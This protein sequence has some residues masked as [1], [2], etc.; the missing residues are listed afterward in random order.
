MLVP[1]RHG[2]SS[3]YRYGYQGSE[4]DD[5]LKGEG[6]SLN[7]TFRMHD[8]RVGRFFAVDPLEKAFHWNSPYAFSENRVLDAI[9]LE[10]AENV[11]LH[12]T[13]VPG[14]DAYDL[15]DKKHMRNFATGLS[16][17]SHHVPNT[18]WNGMGYSSIAR[19]LAAKDIANKIIQYRKDNSLIVEPILVLGHSHGGNVAIEVINILEKHYSAIDNGLG[20][21]KMILITLNTPRL[22]GTYVEN[23]SFSEHYNIYAE[24]DLMSRMGQGTEGKTNLMLGQAYPNAVNVGYVDQLKGN[25]VTNGDWNH[26]GFFE[27]NYNEWKPKLD[28]AIDKKFDELEKQRKKFDENWKKSKNNLND[29]TIKQDNTRVSKPKI[30]NPRNL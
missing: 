6:N 12:G 21:P 1:N 23:G 22:I 2:S 13:L 25:P 24:D 28:V 11:L 19:N 26:M 7:Y 9:E 29:R 30:S 18:T 3:A 14:Q 10:G 5:E 17:N 27:A 8:P 15:W 4:K 16:K 20:A